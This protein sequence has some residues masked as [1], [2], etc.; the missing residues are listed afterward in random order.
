MDYPSLIGLENLYSQ[1]RVVFEPQFE[2][3]LTNLA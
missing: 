3:R 2:K 1:V